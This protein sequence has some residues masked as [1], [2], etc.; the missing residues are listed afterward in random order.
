MHFDLYCK[1]IVLSTPFGNV[2]FRF[3]KAEHR[4]LNLEL[5]LFEN[6]KDPDQVFIFFAKLRVYL[7]SPMFIQITKEIY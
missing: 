5:S 7:K 2:L 3:L 6:T 1:E 4:L